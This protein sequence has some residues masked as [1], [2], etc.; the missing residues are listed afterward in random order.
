MKRAIVALAAFAIACGSAPKKPPAPVVPPP[1]IESSVRLDVDPGIP[2]DLRATIDHAQR[3]GRVLVAL[4]SAAAFA[5]DL[6]ASKNGMNGIVGFLVH[7]RRDALEV[8][9]LAGDP[10]AIARRVQLTTGETPIDQRVDPPA[11]MPAELATLFRA[12]QL[13]LKAAGTL[14]QPVT[15]IVL[16]GRAIEEEGIVVYLLAGTKEKNTAVIGKHIRARVSVDATK[17]LSLEPLSKGPIEAPIKTTGI[18]VTNELADHPFET[19][20]Y[21]SLLHRVPI[22]VKTSRGIWKVNGDRI[23][24][25]SQ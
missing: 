22:Y 13:V 24:F 19:H 6:V 15:P 10:P 1:R 9:F 23:A 16:P 4:G 7:P 3:V 11:E 20:V 18:V 5:N 12:R 8:V 21:A 2:D 17:V 25:E 14:E